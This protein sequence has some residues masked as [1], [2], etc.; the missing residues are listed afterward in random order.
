MID[1]L[2]SMAG[3]GTVPSRVCPYQILFIAVACVGVTHAAVAFVPPLAV[4]IA[5]GSVVG[6]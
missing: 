3:E 4:Q 5:D 1:Q 6:S 2:L